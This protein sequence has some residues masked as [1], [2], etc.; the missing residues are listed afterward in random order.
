VNVLFVYSLQDVNTFNKPLRTPQQIQMGMAYI[1]ALL[2]KNGHKTKV[3]VLS[4]VFEKDNY[5]RIDTTMKAFNPG[6]VL[7]SAVSTEYC[8]I[9]DMAKYIKSTYNDVYTVIGGAHATL[10]PE[11]VLDNGFDALCIGEGEY[12]ALE[13]CTILEKG[14]VP[15]GI[16]NLWIKTASGIE[17]VQDPL[18]E[19]SILLG[20]GCPFLCT[21][22]SNHALRNVAPGKY[23]RYR[24]PENVLREMEDLVNAI[25][26]IRQIYFEV[27][28][29]CINVEETIKLLEKVS[30]FNIK[31]GNSIEYGTNLRVIP[32]KDFSGLFSALKKSN[33]TF[34]NIGLESGSDRVR[35]EILNR[36]YSNE[37][38]IKNVNLA[39]KNNMKVYFFNLI[40]MPTETES[41][42]YETV[43]VNRICQPDRCYTSIFYPYPGTTL[44]TKC[45]DLK[46]IS[47][48]VDVR[49]ERSQ[50]ALNMKQFPKEKV[51]RHYE[52]FDY[53]VYKG[54][55]S[56]YK[57]L[58][59]V[60]VKKLKSY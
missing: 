45:I 12:P 1:S 38:I 16:A 24:S 55:R 54:H 14:G 39:R 28:T 4:S 47:G 56:F 25:P 21:Y 53:Y 30:E 58:L 36:N 7:F 34:I 3:I 48:Y 43:E 35:R 2:E 20:R 40:G 52:W 42:F 51:Q 44:Y 31:I 26:T 19:F 49:I 41:E 17:W 33:F 32:Q 50:A 46:L 22:C 29:I 57:V 9:S 5:Q 23:V 13:L 18:H 60:L 8:F 59:R 15:S 6:L 10:N 37:D 11:G 27:E